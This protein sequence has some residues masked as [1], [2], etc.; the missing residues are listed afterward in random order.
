MERSDV[1]PAADGGAAPP[2][3]RRAKAR[4]KERR[5]SPLVRHK[6]LF[7]ALIVIIAAVVIA[8]YGASPT[9]YLTVTEAS[10]KGSGDGLLIKGVVEPGS[11]NNTTAG[12]RFNLTDDRSTLRVAYDGPVPD[13]MGEGKQIVVEGR[14][15]GGIVTAKKITVGC[16]SKYQ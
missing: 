14:L 7:V 12:I 1:S 15:S 6:M 4:R 16:P 13:G 5:G 10:G 8:S 11:L 3:P 9:T 2:R